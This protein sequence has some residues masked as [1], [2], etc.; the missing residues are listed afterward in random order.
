MH[1]VSRW[2]ADLGLDEYAKLFE[3]HKID[4]EVIAELGESDLKELGIPL[5]HR[6][7]ILK[8]IASL[9]APNAS[10]DSIAGGEAERRQVT[11]MFC[12]LVGSTELSAR[13]DPEDLRAL[14]NAYQDECRAAIAEYDGFVARYMGDGV[15]AYFGYPKSHE[16]DA[17]RAVLAALT[18]LES[19]HA[20][21]ERSTVHTDT[22]LAVRVGIATGLVVVG[23]LIGEGA[24]RESPVIGETPNIA[25]RLQSIAEPDS[26][27][28]AETTHRLA[29]QNF[30]CRALGSRS[31]KGIAEPVPVWM[32]TGTRSVESRFEAATRVELTPLVGREEEISLLLNRWRRARD[33]D[34]QVVLITG[35]PGIGK[36][37]LTEELRRSIASDPQVRISYQCLAH[38][39][40]SALH[41]VIS[42]L[43]RAAGI[44]HRHAPAEKL[45]RLTSLLGDTGETDEE[46]IALFAELLSIPADDR[47]PEIRFEPEQLKEKILSVLVRR[48]EKL[49][50]IDPV[51]CVFEDVHSID[52]STLELLERIVERAA[53]LPVLIIVTCRP[54]FAASW[55]GQPHT[56]LLALSRMDRRQSR[57]IVDRVAQ[58]TGLPEPLLV[59][60]VA[61]TDGIPLFIEEL[62]RALLESERDVGDSPVGI[63][64]TLQDSLMSRLDRL[65]VG[66]SVAQVAS[67]LGR[68]FTHELLA[69]VCEEKPDDID[70]ALDEL[71]DSGLVLRRGTGNQA[72]YVFKHALIQDVAYQSLL[73]SARRAL[74][75]RIASVLCD[76][77]T[78]TAELQPEVV[79]RH[80]S[81]GGEA[82]RAID[83]WQ[84]A[85][86]RAAAR[87]A[88]AEAIGHYSRGLDLIGNIED[89]QRRT[90]AE[91]DFNLGLAASMRVVERWDEAL[92]A[93]GRAETAA[94]NDDRPAELAEVHYL[95]GNL[96]FPL[97]KFDECL[98]EHER[99]RDFC[100]RAGLL[101]KEARALGGLGD[102]YYQRGRMITAEKH[103][104][105]CVRI[106]QKHGFEQI[107]VANLPM[108]GIARMYALRF[109]EGMKDAITS[110]SHA[111]RIHNLRAE[112]ISRQ[113]IGYLAIE[114]EKF[115]EAEHALLEAMQLCRRLGSGNLGAAAQSHYGRLLYELGRRREA[116][117][118]IRE[119]Y[120]NVRESGLRFVGPSIL[121]YLAMATDDPQERIQALHEGEHLLRQGSVS[122]NYFR[123]YRF[124]MEVSLEDGNW[125]ETERYASGLEEYTGAEP[126]PW[127]DFFIERGRALAAH[128]RGDRGE[129]TLDSLAR[130]SARA[131]SCGFASA[132]RALDAALSEQ[133]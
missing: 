5:G 75:R 20:L 93:L 28:I 77:F 97:G 69:A 33:G 103:F 128:G 56:S 16:N 81:E 111:R 131:Q 19:I 130:L 133:I 72:S 11:I 3:E 32:V 24:S 38:H 31:L 57:A 12:D 36:S 29:G 94:R 1:D 44:D 86:D 68:E 109:D 80:F 30:E 102:A 132:G 127:T 45:D 27:L 115:D 92:L 76:E 99:S 124:A 40:G 52:P 100:Q 108:R 53:T 10:L 6:K 74:H 113:S 114:S 54:E 50:D 47:L 59:D 90:T 105:S 98:Q 21:N 73:R 42:Q 129:E 13:F 116:I 26:I 125:D 112:A 122:H 91:V 55:T 123:F 8:A 106:C 120:A 71:D 23:D 9:D 82:D 18:L 96:Y 101:D 14:I 7:K 35:E 2:L 83:Y 17:E 117:S 66:K 78:D 107:E 15:L 70:A 84:R 67:A 58:Q 61:K 4:R 64:A 85:G 37:R 119:A 65:A 34:G 22:R 118:A 39:Q 51:L 63:P 60:I 43:E 87:A 79:A 46:D 95:R 25:A 89:A 88:H 110:A 62:T 126:L 48:L 104:N 121:G 49:A 41:P